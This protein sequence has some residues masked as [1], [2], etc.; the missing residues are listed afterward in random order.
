MLEEFNVDQPIGCRIL[1]NELIKNS[2]SH[3]YIIE[4]NGYTRSNDLVLA[5]IKELFCKNIN[6]EDEKKD[7]CQK[8]DKNIYT[9]LEIIN[10]DGLWIKKDQLS[11]IQYNFKSKPILGDKRIYIIN[12]ADKLNAYAANSILKF[13]EE[14]E[15]GIIAILVAENRNSIISTINSRC[16]II[17]L[18]SKKEKTTL[19]EILENIIDKDKINIVD[20]IEKTITFI[21]NI[22]E[23]GKKT[24]IYVD[25]LFHSYFKE[26]DSIIMFFDIAILF[27]KDIFN[28]KQDLKTVFFENYNEILIKISKENAI[29][30]IIRKINILI[31]LKNDIKYNANNKLIID[32]LIIE[33]DGGNNG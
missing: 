6:N 11:N 18:S 1:K 29:D 21:S 22:E 33:M 23:N 5:F 8:V 12:Q 17:S 13:L 27:Y 15:D 3:A 26:K 20:A 7:I 16:Q 4:T 10:P 14:P 19:E 32:R 2:N 31:Q 25:K 24:I 30:D 28:I 9:E